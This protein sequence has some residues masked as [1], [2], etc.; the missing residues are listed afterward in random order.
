MALIDFEKHQ[1]VARLLPRAAV[2]VNGKAQAICSGEVHDHINP[3]TGLKQAEI[4]LAGAADV[5]AAVQSARRAFPAWRGL[6]PARRA[7]LLNRFAALV[8]QNKERIARIS[9]IENGLPWNMV[10]SGHWPIV[11][12]WMNY[13]AGFADKVE[14]H[15]TASYP[16]ESL[17]YTIPEPFGV[18]GNIIT[19]N[20]PMIS[21]AFK[22][23]P[24]LAAGCTTVVKPSEITPFT[25]IIFAELALEAG[26]PEG[27]INVVPGGA[28]AGEALVRHPGIDKISFTGG[29]ASARKILAA[30]AE[31][32]KPSLYELGGKS[33]NLVF[34]DCDFER[35]A[36]Y[37]AFFPMHGSGQGC[38]L[39]TRLLVEDKIYDRFCEAVVTACR[40]I[41]VG[42]PLGEDSFM[43]PVVNRAALIRIEDY[44]SE[45]KRLNSGRLLLGGNRM[46]GDFADGFF[47]EPTVFADVEPT[48]R[49]A[50]QEIFGPILSVMR[51]K[52]EAE[53]VALAN[54]TSWGLAGYIQTRDLNRAHRVAS[55]LVCGN[56]Y[57]NGCRNVHPAAP[58]GGVGISGFGKEGGRWG[59][60]EFIRHKGVG[61]AI[62]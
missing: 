50:Q 10:L 18:I 62:A 51:F 27:V 26:I 45:A 17:E 47:F 59:I 6:T 23:M 48:S 20:A 35:S 1:S 2:F 12:G 43:G 15:V 52:D 34:A 36:G 38:Q 28:A 44:V 24:C 13:Y 25:A 30:T 19:W 16:S 41:K 4:P 14:G 37:S 9:A 57:I 31:T 32:L 61:I 42:D 11:M 39:P 49:I 56:V 3:A 33:A 46:G 5:D 58:F 21:L 7:E 53:A 29:I 60:E 22:V 40:A 8:D 54:G 55:Q